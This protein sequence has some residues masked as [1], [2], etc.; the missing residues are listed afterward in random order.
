MLMQKTRLIDRLAGRRRFGFALAAGLVFLTAAASR[1]Q[2]GNI[3]VPNYSF[4]LPDIGTNSPYA[5]AVLQSW[6]QTSQ[7]GWY[8]PADFDGA[9]WSDL[10]GTFYNAPDFTNSTETNTSYIGNCVGD[11]AAY[12]QVVP[13]V[14][15]LQVLSAT[16]NVGKT[17]ALT[18]GLIGGGG[19][20]VEGST[21][22]LSLYYLDASSNM[23]TVAASTVTNTTAIFPADT[24]FV[25]FQ[26]EVP[27]VRATDP[28]AGQN[29]GILLL[30]TP[31]F[32]DPPQWGGYWDVGNVRL[33]E[34]TALNLVNPAMTNGQLQFTVQSE[35]GVVFQILATTNLSLPATNWTGLGTLTNL[36]G[37]LSIVDQ[38]AAGLGQRFYTAR[39]AP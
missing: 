24:N 2:A 36:T 22:Q 39:Q 26:V 5:A 8:S 1:V 18:V 31:D 27:G 9:P 16:F 20:M 33:I 4:A 29:I 13:Q 7:P 30:A 34:T 38:T 23:V 28:W 35:P 25:D 37:S 11:Q 3:Y 32:Y 15:I 12:L 17:Y 19:G 14:G 10:A 6:Q 21:F